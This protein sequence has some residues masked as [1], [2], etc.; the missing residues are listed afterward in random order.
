[1]PQLMKPAYLE[2][3][4]QAQVRSP[5][6][7]RG[8]TIGGQGSSPPA[9]AQCCLSPVVGQVETL[10]STLGGTVTSLP[11]AQVMWGP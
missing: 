4:L 7:Q 11:D 5:E 3:V 9:Q 10:V 8:Q 2:P 1:M 6:A